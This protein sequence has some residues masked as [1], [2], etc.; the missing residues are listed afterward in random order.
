MPACQLLMLLSL[1]L[2]IFMCVC[3]LQLCDV[4]L[5]SHPVPTNLAM[6]IEHVVIGVSETQPVPGFAQFLEVEAIQKQAGGLVQQLIG[7]Y[8]HLIFIGKH[9]V[10]P[11]ET[12]S[13]IRK[14]LFGTSTTD[15]HPS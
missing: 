14:L 4:R 13:T 1:I 2:G 6:T 5:Q 15:H 10:L 3:D 7:G 12:I 8:N 11:N 9:L